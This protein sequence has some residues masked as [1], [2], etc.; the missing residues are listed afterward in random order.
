MRVGMFFLICLVS[1]NFTLLEDGK[2]TGIVKSAEKGQQFVV[3]VISSAGAEKNS[4]HEVSFKP[5]GKTIIEIN[6]GKLTPDIS[7]F[8]RGT[9]VE[10]KNNTSVKHTLHVATIVDHNDI[11]VEGNKSRSLSFRLHGIYNIRCKLHAE[12]TTDF[13]VTATLHSAITDSD[14]KFTISGLPSGT[15]KVKIWSKDLKV[16]QLNSTY[17][18]KINAGKESQMEIVPPSP[19]TSG[20]VAG[21]VNSSFAKKFPFVVYIEDIGSK[22]LP[23]PD[24]NALVDQYAKVFVPRVLPVQVGTAVDFLNSDPFEHNVLSPDEEKYDLG[25]FGKG[26]SRSYVFKRTG[27]YTQLCTLHPEMIAYVVVVKTPFFAV[28]DNDGNFKIEG[29]PAGSWKVKIWNE[30]LKSKQLAKTWDI[31]VETDKESGLVIEP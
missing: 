29:V 24:E 10:F 1:L 30:R 20:T 12:E 7:T 17:E 23:V 27:F 2:L 9:E 19:D 11:D 28:T 18:V 21:K 15:F 4:G 3:Y 14:G 31:T 16:S 22:T 5:A 8:P 6:N 13:V 26:E 25:N